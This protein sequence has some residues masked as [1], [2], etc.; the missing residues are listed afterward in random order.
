MLM[1]QQNSTK[2]VF[3]QKCF[4]SEDFINYE[5]WIMNYGL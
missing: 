2:N 4:K 3:F 5:L 1:N